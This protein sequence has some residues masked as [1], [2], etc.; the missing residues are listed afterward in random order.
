M[1]KKNQ[2]GFTLMELMITV[3]IIGILAS[4]ALPAYQSTVNK[5]RRSDAY[6]ALL[7]CAAA[8]ARA[9][10][11]SAQ[12]S[13]LNQEAATAA[14]RC[15]NSKEGFY[16]LAVTNSNCTTQVGSN[17]LFWCFSVT[18]TATG[19]QTKDTPCRTLTVDHT[20]RK[21]ATDSATVDNTAEC[22]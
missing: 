4:I 9:Y 17:N 16:T 2:M 10:T 6:D 19:S 7:D 14:G 1:I 5:A 12:P 3:A 20:G 13:Y 21:T 11:T 18:A 15:P 22:W 8:Q